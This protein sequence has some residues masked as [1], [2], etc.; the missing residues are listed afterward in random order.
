[1]NESCPLRVLLVE[2]NETHRHL[3]RRHLTKS[4]GEGIQLTQTDR[5]QEA[6]NELARGPYDAVLLD[7]SLPD[8]PLTETLPRLIDQVTDVPVVVLTS[9]GDLDFASQLVQQGADDFLVKSEIT[10]QTLLRSI[11]YAIERKKNQ[12]KLSEYAARLKKRNEELKSFAHTIAHEV[13]SPLN[14]VS[15]CLSLVE[16]EQ[17]GQLDED[18]MEAIADAK[19]AIKGMA[20]LVTDLLDFSRAEHD[21]SQ[22]VPVAMQSLLGEV[23]TS[24]RTELDQA[25]AELQAS[26]LPEVHG[27]PV[28][29]RQLLKNLISNA[30]KYRHPERVPSVSVWVAQRDSEWLVGVD[31][32]G[33]GIPADR[34]ADV[35]SPFVRAHEFTG[36]PGTG[37]G[38][39][40]CRRIVEAHGGEIWIEQSSDAGTSLRFTIEKA[41][42]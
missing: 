10:G 20:E 31:D 37:I 15:C 21:Q 5:L 32:N 6:L 42:R 38:L 12:I 4:V 29:L 11:R 13:R 25:Q 2:D 7:L 41:A 22:H 36:V 17:A 30:I 9:L 1:M 26:D 24:L 35:F 3:I 19:A 8:S 33:I 40:Y 27:N 23:R 28:Q 16:E 39:A 34:I 18:S 14:V